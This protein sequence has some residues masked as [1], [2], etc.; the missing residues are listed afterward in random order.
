MNCQLYNGYTCS[1]IFNKEV[2]I[3]NNNTRIFFTDPV[4]NTDSL[5][6]K[7]VLPDNLQNLYMSFKGGS[8]FNAPVKLG[9]NAMNCRQ[10]FEYSKFFSQPVTI[11]NN[12]TD[13]QLMFQNC[14]IFNASVTIGR[15][16]TNC[17][18]MFSNCITLNSPIIFPQQ[19]GLNCICQNMFFN[20]LSFNQPVSLGNGVNNCVRMFAN[21]ISFNQSVDIP[22]SVKDCSSMF[23]GC[24]SFNHPVTFPDGVLETDSAFS[25]CGNYNSPIYIPDSANSYAKVEL[26][27]C[28]KSTISYPSIPMFHDV[29]GDFHEID[30]VFTSLLPNGNRSYHV[31]MTVISR[32]DA[33]V[34]V[35][36]AWRFV[37]PNGY[38]GKN[39]YSTEEAIQVL[40][41]NYKYENC[42]VEYLEDVSPQLESNPPHFNDP[43]YNA[44]PDLSGLNNCS[45]YYKGCT[46]LNQQINLPNT[47]YRTDGMFADCIKFNSPVY[48]EN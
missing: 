8:V 27:G 19:V 2:N 47:V 30:A 45:Y 21:C 32:S 17:I 28:F 37:Y 9:K 10:M 34:D 36:K 24:S 38:E 1:L 35:L 4:A 31:G 42:R 22:S 46:N 40:C 12:V 41:N 6:S 16:V 43:T 18:N 44:K 39:N 15:N 14:T 3:L 23:Y 5:N 29:D 11:P 25:R 13:C 33:F 20:C 7:V 26:G 48:F